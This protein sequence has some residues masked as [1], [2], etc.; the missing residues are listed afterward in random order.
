MLGPVRTFE[1]GAANGGSEPTP[2]VSK[3]RCARS[4]HGF[5]RARFICNAAAR[6]E[7]GMSRLML[8]FA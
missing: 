8:N 7:E 1:Q 5:C 4:Q 6:R 2:E 3:S